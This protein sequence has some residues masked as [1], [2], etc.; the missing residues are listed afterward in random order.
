MGMLF[1]RAIFRALRGSRRNASL[2]ISRPFVAAPRT[3]VLD[4]SFNAV[5]GDQEGVAASVDEPATVLLD[6]RIDQI[7]PEA[8]KPS[9]RSHIVEAH[10]LRVAN[11]VHV[12]ERGEPPPIS[13]FRAEP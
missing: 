3:Q 1:V 10:R 12:D 6:C 4:G 5:E 13:R 11:H 8:L 9:Q 7:A 2:I